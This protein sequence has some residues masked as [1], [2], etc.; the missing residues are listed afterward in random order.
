MY[1]PAVY[2]FLFLYVLTL[3]VSLVPPTAGQGINGE[4]NFVQ[5]GSRISQIVR[6]TTKQS[7]NITHKN[8]ITGVYVL[9]T[10]Q[11]LSYKESVGKLN[12]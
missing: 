10:C 2:C 1:G 12:Q 9:Q 11:R 6:E 4:Y 5:Q 3:I 7:G 8:P